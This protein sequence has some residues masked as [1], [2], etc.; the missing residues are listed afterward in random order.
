M[1]EPSAWLYE[2][3]HSGHLHRT[4]LRQ[5]GLHYYGERWTETP[6]YTREAIEAEI[7]AWLRDCT[8]SSAIPDDHAQIVADLAE[9]I[10]SGEYMS[11][12]G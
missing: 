6:L 5:A 8:L 11:K 1:T 12:S 7:V 2:R 9:A 3:G 4:R 10:E